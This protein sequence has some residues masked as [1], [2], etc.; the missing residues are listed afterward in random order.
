[1][2]SLLYGG[3]IIVIVNTGCVV[4]LWYTAWPQNAGFVLPPSG[5]QAFIW[6]MEINL[7]ALDPM[8]C[9]PDI[10]IAFKQHRRPRLFSRQAFI[11][12]AVG[13]V[14]NTNTEF[15]GRTLW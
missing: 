2:D 14:Q 6:G 1:M 12:H 4:Y 15:P 8:D 5:K 11:A 13:A 7:Q 10:L 3:V 9:C